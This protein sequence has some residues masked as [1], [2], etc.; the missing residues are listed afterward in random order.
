MK[1]TIVQTNYYDFDDDVLKEYLNHCN[2]ENI[3]PSYLDFID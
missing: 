3:D 2:E 1:A